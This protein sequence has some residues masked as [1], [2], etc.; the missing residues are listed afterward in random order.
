[1]CGQQ[2]EKESVVRPDRA[3]PLEAQSSPGKPLPR[4]HALGLVLGTAKRGPH[5]PGPPSGAVALYGA[6]PELPHDRCGISDTFP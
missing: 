4:A 3:V 6:A 5:P 1:M 2:A